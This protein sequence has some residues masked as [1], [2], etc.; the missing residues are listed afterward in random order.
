MKQVTLDEAKKRLSELLKEAGEEAIVILKD[1]KPVGVLS[2]WPELDA[3]S[4]AR[5]S[6]ADF[7]RMIQSRRKS[8]TVPWA[9]AKT[10]AGL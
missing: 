4:L 6:S 10:Q 9:Q 1:G 2:V 3:E 7:W 8:E 5:A